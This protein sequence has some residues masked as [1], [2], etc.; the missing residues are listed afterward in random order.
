VILYSG[1]RNTLI[2]I[3]RNPLSKKTIYK[4][5]IQIIL[6]GLIIFITGL[7]GVYLLLKL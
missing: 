2:S 3:G 4:G 1:V 6:M 5:L 7:F